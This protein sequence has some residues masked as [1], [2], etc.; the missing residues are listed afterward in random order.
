MKKIILLSIIL[1]AIGS[2]SPAN[3]CDSC[4]FFEYSLLQ[5]KSYFGLF[6]RFRDFKD[7]KSF[8]NSTSSTI[9][10][11]PAQ[12]STRLLPWGNDMVMHE[13][14]GNNLFV[15]KTKQDF[16]TY[17]TIEARGNFT[18]D[19][20]WNFTFLLPYEFNKVYYEKYLDLPKPVRDTTLFVQGW[21]DLTVAGEYIHL[22]YNPKSRH[23]IRP[24]LALTLPTGQALVKSNTET[25]D[26]FDPI[27]QPGKG[28]FS[29][30]PRVNYQWFL[31]NHGVNVGLS[32]Q[33]STEGEQEYEFGNSFNSYALYFHQFTVREKLLIVPSAGF[34]YE[35][36]NKDLYQKELQDL[37]GGSVGFAQLGLDLNLTQTTFSII[38]QLPVVQ[39]LNGNQI[40]NQN[41]F[42]VGI[43][44]SFKL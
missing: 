32:Y 7:Y 43:I 8:S 26:Y 13:P 15:Q 5:N 28:S 9:Q 6:Y 22:I 31:K 39:N 10:N 18:L 37:T 2:F 3:A 41:R 4:N 36:S 40:L 42:S 17:Q 12:L 20:K 35:Q 30:T 27:I 19:N 44:R 14:E 21:G 1:F 23:T 33:W 16:E 24:G 25:Q 11:Y 29:F 34:Y 38:T